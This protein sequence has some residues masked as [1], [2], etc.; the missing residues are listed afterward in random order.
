M[1]RGV[2]ERMLP[3]LVMERVMA[4]LEPGTRFAG[5]LMASK[6]P[7]RSMVGLAGAG[8]AVRSWRGSRFSRRKEAYERRAGMASSLWKKRARC[9]VVLR[10]VDEL[11][12]I[13]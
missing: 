13:G 6:E 11:L 9:K 7:A 1:L 12:R 8:A 4:P 3:S 5:S 10:L 2:L